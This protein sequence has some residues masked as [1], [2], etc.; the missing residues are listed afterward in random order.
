MASLDRMLYLYEHDPELADLKESLDDFESAQAA[1]ETPKN[2][3]GR[4]RNELVGAFR[5]S[6]S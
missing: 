4:I 1:R 6:R 5:P 3:L 2:L